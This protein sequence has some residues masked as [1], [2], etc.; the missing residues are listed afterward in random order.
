MHRGRRVRWVVVAVAAAAVLIASLRLVEAQSG[1]RRG[2]SGTRRPGAGGSTQRRPVRESY[3][4]RFWNWLQS[5]Q[6]Q[7][8][9][10]MPGQTADAYPGESPHGARLKMYVNRTAASDPE[11]LPTG[12]VL[13]KENY[14]EDGE[15]LMAVTVM[16]RSKNYDPEHGDWYWVK[17]EPDGRVS[18]TDEG[19]PIAGHVQKCA[20]CH[21]AAAGGDFS[22]ANDR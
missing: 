18:R 20:E 3:E 13:I 14:A 9:S 17:Y 10:P 4:S 2:G 11:S 15:T 7:N 19:K 8:W 21:S 5:V 6:Y 12:S 22:F 1:S 16:Y